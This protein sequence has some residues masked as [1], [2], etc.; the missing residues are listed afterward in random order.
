MALRAVWAAEAPM[1]KKA[2]AQETA[3]EKVQEAIPAKAADK[4]SIPTIFGTS[5]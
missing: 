2:Q 4:P 5:V 1:V 3:Q